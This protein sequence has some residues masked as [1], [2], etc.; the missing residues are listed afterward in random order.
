MTLDHLR[1]ASLLALGLIV[2]PLQA[3]DDIVFEVLPGGLANGVSDDGAFVV[4]ENAAG[5]FLWTL[6]GT[7]SLGQI[8]GIA[9]GNYAAVGGKLRYLF[10]GT[11]L[12]ARS[13]SPWRWG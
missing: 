9:G 10:R 13:R 5:A 12:L 2:L 6:E 4:G 1:P 8:S 7:T 3:G 11:H